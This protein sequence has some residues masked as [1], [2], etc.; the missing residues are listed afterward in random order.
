MNTCVNWSGDGRAERIRVVQRI[1]IDHEAPVENVFSTDCIPFINR[2]GIVF[3]IGYLVASPRV[4]LALTVGATTILGSTSHVLDDAARREFV[5]E[6][7]VSSGESSIRDRDG[8]LFAEYGFT[9]EVLVEST[10]IFGACSSQF[11]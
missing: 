6:C 7:D 8:E 10:D 4:E 3:S 11:L 1:I 2:A 9:S 5:D